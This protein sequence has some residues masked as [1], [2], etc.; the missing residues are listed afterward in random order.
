MA[1]IYQKEPKNLNGHKR[2]ML[3]LA[4]V[5]HSQLAQWKCITREI[6]VF[7]GEWLA[8]YMAIDKN[9]DLLEIEIKSSYGDFVADF[10]KGN[11]YKHKKMM[12]GK[13]P[14]KFMFAVIND[15]KKLLDKCENYLASNYPKYGLVGLYRRADGIYWVGPS[16]RPARS[17]GKDTPFSNMRPKGSD[18]YRDEYAACLRPHCWY[19]ARWMARII[20]QHLEGKK[21]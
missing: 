18:Y 3:Y 2:L 21:D 11:G 5:G 16:I 1:V 6:R 9:G 7:Y 17:I 14:N 19:D 10:K 4:M 20:E 13:G 12:E 15:G 8:D